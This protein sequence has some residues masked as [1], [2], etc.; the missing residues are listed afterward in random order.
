MSLGALRA[1]LAFSNTQTA[2]AHN[3]SY[4]ITLEQGIAH[5]LACSFCLPD[6]MAAALG[7]DPDCDAALA[8][9]FGDLSSASGALREFLS[10]L[11]VST[12]FTDYGVTPERWRTIVAEASEGPRGRNFI[13]AIDH[14]PFPPSAAPGSAGVHA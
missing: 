6:V 8:E 2:L 12:D 7:A 9:I 3:I 5:G 11:G 1:G 14:F 13:G 4:A 10:D